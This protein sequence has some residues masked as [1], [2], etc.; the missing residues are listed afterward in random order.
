[1]NSNDFIE[2]KRL[3]EI[4]TFDKINVVALD[5]VNLTLEEGENS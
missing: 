2:T 5:N 1:M 3:N 4:Y